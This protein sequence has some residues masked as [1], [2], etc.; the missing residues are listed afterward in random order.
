ML[1]PTKHT[2]LDEMTTWSTTNVLHSSFHVLIYSEC[3]VIIR[4]SK[5]KNS[6][7]IYIQKKFCVLFL[8]ADQA[9]ITFYHASQLIIYNQSQ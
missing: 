5:W 4:R 8:Y 9:V 2:Q 7:L 1:A 3:V 6:I